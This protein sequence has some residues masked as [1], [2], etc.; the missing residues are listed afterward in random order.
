MSTEA[1]IAVAIIAVLV[2]V[3][4][5]AVLTV[6]LTRRR[7]L[8]HR[9]GPEYD[10][11]VRSRGNRR[12][13]ERELA[14]RE[15]RVAS[16]R[17]R[18]LEPEQRQRYSAEWLAVQEQF[19]DDPGGAVSAA[20]RLVTAVMS[21]RGYPTQGYEQGVSDLSVRHGRVVDHYRS[22]HQFSGRAARGEASTEELRQAMVHYR[23]LLT[24]LLDEQGTVSQ[25]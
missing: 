17:I 11:T 12:H 1:V 3:L 9:F 22:A 7:R 18:P 21:E 16:Y 6:L 25:D 14:E 2:I 19:V 5:T 15:R 23:E 4:V 20:Q 10:R 8:R 24:D 13:A